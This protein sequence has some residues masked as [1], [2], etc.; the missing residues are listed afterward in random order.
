VK[1]RA[2]VAARHFQTA[3][4]GA[5][6]GAYVRGGKQMNP[7]T[8]ILNG[9]AAG[10]DVVRTLGEPDGRHDDAHA[11]RWHFVTVYRPI[12]E[13]APGGRVPERLAELGDA[14]DV[15]IRPAADEKGTEIGARLR[16]GVPSGAGEPIARISG[17]DPRQEL[18]LRLRETKALIEC[19]EVVLPEQRPSTK[20][21]LTNLPLEL[22]VR[23]SRGEGRL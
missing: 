13:V 8:L 23:R 17:N 7:K 18:R 22:A 6:R 21:T 20:R 14:I 1:T 10:A 12:E 15:E 9:L 19:G 4:C 11:D 2:R 5:A 16:S 3:G